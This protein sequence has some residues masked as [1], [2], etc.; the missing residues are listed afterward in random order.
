MRKKLTLFKAAAALVMAV[1]LAVTLLGCRPYD[2]AEG[3]LDEG[4]EPDPSG[5]VKL[6]YYIAANDALKKAIN[7]YVSAFNQKYSNVKV[8]TSLSSRT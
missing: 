8:Q 6:N 5:K 4:Y 2:P 3:I 1:L 7:D